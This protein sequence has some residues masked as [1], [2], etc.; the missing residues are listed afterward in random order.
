MKKIID[1]I[2]LY[3]LGFGISFFFIQ[4]CNDV[5]Y[6]TVIK[7]KSISGEWNLKDSLI[8]KGV[9]S[10]AAKA[11]FV[12]HKIEASQKDESVIYQNYLDMKKL[13]IDEELKINI[14]DNK[15]I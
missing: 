14:F 12:K 13:D 8:P 4:K 10:K 2:G 11:T 9:F 6:L 15:K 5:F 1:C 3:F 7:R